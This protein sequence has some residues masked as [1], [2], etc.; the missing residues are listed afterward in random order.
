[1]PTEYVGCVWENL[2]SFNFDPLMEDEPLLLP[3]CIGITFPNTDVLGME[4]PFVKCCD[5]LQTP[6]I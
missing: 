1:M 4:G 3:L 6:Y 2:L 5:K